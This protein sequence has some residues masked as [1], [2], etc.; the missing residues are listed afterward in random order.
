MGSAWAEPVQA[1]P[2]ASPDP[3]VKSSLSSS[4]FFLANTHECA[5]FFIKKIEVRTNTRAVIPGPTDIT[6]GLHFKYNN[7]GIH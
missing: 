4:P 2:K 6:T 7:L 1:Q 5:Y 3:E